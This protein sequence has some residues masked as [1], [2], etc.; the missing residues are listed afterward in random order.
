MVRLGGRFNGRQIVPAS[1]VARIRTGGSTA[2][3]ARAIWDYNTRRGW[4]YGS[5]WWHTHNPNGAF[6]GIGLHGQALYI[7][8]KAEMV[9]VQFRSGPDGSTVDF[10]YI[11]HP[12]FQA[13]ADHL[14]GK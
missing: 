1:V 2:D 11:I 3:F 10:D 6:M 7:D 4:S 14:S 12:M 13:L 8:P 5:Q 9:I